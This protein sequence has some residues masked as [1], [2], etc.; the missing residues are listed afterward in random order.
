MPGESLRRSSSPTRVRGPLVSILLPTHN[1]RR[2]LAEA[3][4]SAVRQTHGN[5]EILVVRDGGEEVA[6][7]VRSF[8]DPR[9][10]LIDRREN[11]G[12]PFSLNEALARA[13]GKYVAYLDDDD[14]YYPYHIEVLVEALE[15]RADSGVAYSDLYKTYCE[16]LAGGG[17]VVLS[18]HVEISRD[19]D[20]F[21]MLYFNHVLHVSLMHRRDLLDKTGLYNENLNILIDWDMTRRLA[22]F[23]DFH[24]VPL[25]TGE[26]YSPVGECDRIS[27]RQRK[28]P[29][30]YLRNILAIRTTRPAPPWS[31]IKDLSIILLA[32]RADHD[33]ADTMLRIWRYTFYP[34]KLFVPL[35]PDELARLN[36]RMPN[37]ELIPVPALSSPGVRLDA[38][39]RASADGYV[40][41][42]S[43]GL[44]LEEMWIEY[45]LYALS[46]S[47]GQEGFLAAGATPPSWAIVLRRNDLERARQAY[48]LPSVEASLAAAGIRM[49]LPREEELPFQFDELLRQAKLAE[50]DGNWMTAARLFE[51]MGERFANTLWMRAMAARAYFEAGDHER[52]GQL[53]HEANQERPTVETLLLEAK[54]RR[55]RRDF[56]IAIRLLGQAE[57]LLG[58]HDGSPPIRPKSDL[59]LR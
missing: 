12:K 55:H 19:F 42:V 41:V 37:V 17:R 11:R 29:E 36:V 56:A 51:Q 52:A 44:A 5:L 21:L 15:S 9:V 45:P 23:C 47:R 34:Y 40:A 25:V 39:L 26:F 4:A 50:A 31:R 38:A 46:D 32:E 14:V 57:Q 59:C 8:D 54:V 27:I 16:V 7:V 43:A 6:D 58:T 48:P 20:R 53:S 28:E 1:R 3:L 2:Y 18:K 35:P 22:F 30:E 10:I 13:R 24:H 33:A 49:R